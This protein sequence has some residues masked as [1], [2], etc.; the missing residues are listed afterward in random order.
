MNRKYKIS[1]S[2]INY[3]PK[4]PELDDLTATTFAYELLQKGYRRTS[5]A[6]CL[7]SRIDRDDWLQVLA[8]Q[9]N[10]SVAD[11]YKMDGTGVADNCDFLTWP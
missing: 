9:L 7:V 5:N 10:C 4:D 1:L 6:Y 3:G 11:F 2:S 8:K